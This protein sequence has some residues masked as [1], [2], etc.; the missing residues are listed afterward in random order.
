MDPQHPLDPYDGV[1]M[2][3][4]SSGYASPKEPAAE[5][6]E[7]EGARNSPPE[8]GEKPEGE[9]QQEEEEQQEGA[10]QQEAEKQQEGEEQQEGEGQQEG[11]EAEHGEP[12]KKKRA[13]QL[14]AAQREIIQTERAA[15]L[16]YKAIVNK[17]PDYGFTYSGVKDA[18]ARL[19][20]NGTLERQAGSGRP[21]S[22][23]SEAN[24]AAI[25]SAVQ[26]NPRVSKRSLAASTGIK[27]SSVRNILKN[28]LGMKS[29]TQIKAQRIKKVNTEA[30]LARCQEWAQQMENG[31]EFDPR[32]VF[33]TDEKVFRLGKT[34]GG[35]Q[36]YRVWV[37]DGIKKAQLAP[38]DILRDEGE[39][40]GGRT[41]MVALGVCYNGVGTLRFTPKGAIVNS[42]KYK[43]ILENTYA[44]DC[45]E[46][47][48]DGDF[49]FQQD[50]ASAHTSHATQALC[51]E[52]F[53]NF[54]G[55]KSWPPTS[56]DLNVLDFFVWGY[57]QR[58]VERLNPANTDVAL[59][60]AIRSALASIPL[61]MVRSAIDS[62]YKRCILCNMAGGAQFKHMLKR[63]DLPAPPERAGSPAAADPHEAPADMEMYEIY[64][65]LH[66]ADIEAEYEEGEEAEESE[67]GEHAA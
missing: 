60:T 61:P 18:L 30:R 21:K 3:S 19:K 40:Q 57:M 59:K 52:L 35:N 22:G 34:S 4:V 49:T 67:N 55:K 28:D 7:A 13:K 56:P 16:G 43:D 51:K 17:Y 12:A 9:E 45:A 62:F 33:W 25:N 42:E 53:P 10:E 63:K 50:G 27:V 5:K 47:F 29:L 32:K 48:P 31:W 38:E 20:K 65:P 23:R 6:P 36:N 58:E 64:E 39:M 41:V 8:G 66:A 26:D 11:E 46:L 44:V 24:V 14:S 15:G 54:I 1:D 2:L 37:H